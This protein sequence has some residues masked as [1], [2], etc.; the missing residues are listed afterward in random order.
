MNSYELTLKYVQKY[1]QKVFQ[2]H[3]I[4]EVFSVA[5]PLGSQYQERIVAVWGNTL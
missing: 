5:I 4:S 3:V 1:T 2:R